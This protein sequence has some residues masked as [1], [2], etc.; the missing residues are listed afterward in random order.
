MKP[1]KENFF[2]LANMESTE[3]SDESSQSLS[4]GKPLLYNVH[5][6]LQE[7]PN[8]NVKQLAKAQAI[9]LALL[10]FNLDGNMNVGMILRT[11]VVFGITKVYIVGRKRY[12][13]RST[14]GAKH[15]LDLHF[16]PTIDDPVT[17]F[18]EHNLQPIML[19]QGG[20]PLETFSFGSYIKNATTKMPCIVL[21]CESKGIPTS[22]LTSKL[23]PTIS[24]SQMGVL[25]SLNVS[26][27][28]SIV[29]YEYMKQWREV[30]AAK[31]HLL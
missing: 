25:R 5:T 17:F 15:Y 3:S 12:D 10:L 21:G 31:L 1:N 19:E 7:V 18:H 28:A 20:E 23:G 24:I 30:T 8:E 26:I 4:K 9:P 11:A 22:W 29:L 6:I 2:L 13:A 14:V 16:V 27:A